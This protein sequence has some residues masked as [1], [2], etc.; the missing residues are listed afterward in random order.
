MDNI[1]DRIRKYIIKNIVGRIFFSQEKR[2]YQLVLKTIGQADKEKIFADIVKYP[3]WRNATKDKISDLYNSVRK[4]I[5]ICYHT[6]VTSLQYLNLNDLTK[7]YIVQIQDKD[8]KLGI[9]DMRLMYV[10]KK[11]NTNDRFLVLSSSRLAIQAEDILEV[12]DTAMWGIGHC[13]SFK[14]F[15]TGRRIPS[16]D[17]LYLTMPLIYISIQTPSIVHEVIDARSDFSHAEYKARQNDSGEYSLAY[18]K[19]SIALL[20]HEFVG[21]KGIFVDFADNGIDGSIYTEGSITMATHEGLSVFCDIKDDF[22][23]ENNIKTERPGMIRVDG[24]NNAIK[25]VERIK[26]K[27][28][29]N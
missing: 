15:R 1:T 29:K 12:Y 6:K 16:E 2:S 5:D 19:P 8:S 14:V 22:G 4:E 28:W 23:I 27:R 18:T 13:V 21:G 7:G 3:G 11:Q 26:V 20:L 25:L 17:L 10:G 24:E 9:G